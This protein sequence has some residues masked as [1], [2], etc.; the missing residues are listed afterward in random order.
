VMIT[1]WHLSNYIKLIR[2]GFQEDIFYLQNRA[3]RNRQEALSMALMREG[4]SS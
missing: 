2:K 3:V 4:A 1:N